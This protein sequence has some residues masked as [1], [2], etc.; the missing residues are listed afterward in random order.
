MRIPFFGKKKP[1]KAINNRIEVEDLLEQNFTC[2]EVAEELGVSVEEVYRIKNAKYRREQRL[3]GKTFNE[4]GEVEKN[5]IEELKLELTKVE[6]QD[7][8]D[9]AKHKAQMRE[10]ERQDAMSEDYDDVS[11]DDP[12]KLIQTLLLNTMLKRQQPAQDNPTF[13][14]P[15]PT[16][17]P[18]P[19]AGVSNQ[20]PKLPTFDEIKKGIDMGLI[21]EER[22]AQELAP[23]KVPKDKVTKLYDFIKNDL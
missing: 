23:F 20:P 4:A 2:G 3:K 1:E 5:P 9:E 11:G 10:I 6:L 12:D 19:T 7:K 15:L 16:N 17:A 14:L 22:V 13:P 21:S 18:Q 8:I